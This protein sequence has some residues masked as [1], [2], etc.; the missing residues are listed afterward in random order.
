MTQF[1]DLT[2]SLDEQNKNQQ[3]QSDKAAQ[4]DAVSKSGDKVASAIEKGSHDTAKALK[5]VKGEVQVTNPDLAKTQD[6]DKAV[7]AIK[8]LNLTTFMSNEG[9]P[10][11]VKNLDDLSTKTQVMQEKMESEGLKKVSDQLGQLVTKL[12]DVS[13][14]LSKTEVSVDAKLQKTIDNLSKRIDAIDFNP[15]V[16]V[17]APDTKVVTTPVNLD[18]VVTALSKVE[19]AIQNSKQPE[20]EVD[21]APVTQGLQSV[22]NAIAALRFPVPNY[23]L[24]FRSATGKAVQV[25]LNDDGTLPISSSGGS[26]GTQY[27]D[28][29]VPPAHPVGNTIEWSDGSNWQTVSTAKPLPVTASISTAGL[30]TTATDTNTGTI[31]SAVHAED[32]ASADGDKGIT[33]LATRKGTPANTSGSDGDYETLQMSAGRLWVDASGKT[34]TVDGSGVTQPISAASLPLPS[35]AA[36]ST[37]QSDGT[38]KTQ[39]VDGSG[40]VIGA[41]SNALDINI[42]SGNPTTITATQGTATNLKTQSETYQGGTAVASGNPL[43]VTLA[44][45]GANSTAVK[46]DGSAVTQPVSGTLVTS[47][48]DT[49]PATQNITAVDAVTASTSNQNAQTF[50][51]GTP[52]AGSAASFTLSGQQSVRLLVTGTWSA[53]LQAEYSVDGGTT[54]H[55][56]LMHQNSIYNLSTGITSNFTANA[57]TTGMTSVRIRCT[58]Y[59]SG[60]AV[61]RVVESAGEA[62]ISLNNAPPSGNFVSTNNSSAAT[63]TSGSVFTGISDDAREYSEIRITVFADQVSAT[64]G[65]SIQQSTDNTNW[66]VTDTYTVPITSAG[67]GKTYSVPRQARYFR[68]VYTNGGT[69][70]G[71]FRLQTILNRIATTASSQRA[72]DA[73][74]NENDLEQVWS[75]NSHWNGTTWDRKPGTTNGGYEIIR[76]A[77]GNAR[78]ANVSAGNA[79]LVDASATTQPVSYATTGSGTA[80]GALRV[81]IANN[82]TGTLATVSTLTGTTTLTPGTG[83]TNLGKAEDAAHTSGDTGV[84]ALAVRNDNLATTYTNTDQDYSPMAVDLN[85]RTMVA[86][87]TATA[88]LSNVAASA[89]SVTVLA[90]NASRIGATI[91]NDSSSVIYVKFGTTA[92]TTSYTVSLAGSAAAPFSYYEVPAGYTG[93]IDA[94][95]ASATGNARV[96]EMT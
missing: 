3:Q 29:G 67:N 72:S 83:A 16:N 14:L 84:F 58:A 79:L 64:N 11:L 6:V 41:T 44:N 36:T 19:K 88:T 9:L 23:V 34:L 85:G 86:Q 43:Q 92:S 27:T 26:A 21:L 18:P 82:G 69:N 50:Y 30:A 12:S 94:I 4:L 10:Q 51:T 90:A 74:S 45:T 59:T 81:E 38:Q 20:T 75:F 57:Q 55:V 62:V 60:T 28:G 2:N 71:T 33:L 96:T 76:D 39:V 42:K 49:V 8:Q 95:W 1:S 35:T 15:S 73:Y 17:S 70:Q 66:D 78:G 61:V 77:A 31:A 13:R 53:T 54:W 47:Y 68:I 40:N 7:E 22:Q 24:P 80:T 52:T 89:T 56:L 25:Q 48:S 63:L 91:T 37:K 32:A 46:V 87:K 65:L 93:R 5:E